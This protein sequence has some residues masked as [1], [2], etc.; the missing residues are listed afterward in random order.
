MIF[1]ERE[2]I[3]VPILL[4]A[5]IIALLAASGS[6][7]QQ[8]DDQRR[9]IE[10]RRRQLELEGTQKQYERSQALS[11]KGLISETDLERDKNNVATAQLNYQQAVL[12]LLDLQPRLSV[13]SAVKT[14]TPDGRKFVQLV[15]ANLTPTFDDSQFKLLNNFQGADPIP[16]ALRTRVI[17]DIFVSLR[18]TGAPAGSESNTSRAVGATISLPYE[19]H[20]PQMKYSETK[21]LRYQLLRDV[22]S[23]VVAI[24]YRNQTQEVT[25]Q[26]QHAAGGSELQISS[27]QFSQ[28]GDLGSQA[29]YNITLERPTVDVRSFQLN[30]VNLPRQVS[31]SFVDLQTQARLS[32]I[33]FPTGVTRQV[34]GLRL[35]LPERSDEQVLV[36]QELRFWVLG[37]DEA[38]AAKFGEDRP[39]TEA[40]LAALGS[41]KL[42]LTVIPRGVGRIEVTAPSLFSEIETGQELET[43]LTVRSAGT[44]RLD[45]IKLL[46]EYP[47]NWRVELAPDIIPSLEIDR[48]EQ[49]K[50]RVIPPADVGVGDYEIRL[51]TESFAANRRVQSEDKVYRISVKS[52]ADLLK[53][54]ALIGGLLLL[55]IGIVVF[56][57]KT[58]RR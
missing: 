25:V 42:R 28:E 5:I 53:T 41:S 44:R 11:S 13:R 43:Q 27:S 2:K 6:P 35:F 10:V 3:F 50:L 37:L 21:P 4:S 54:G 34:L 52:K 20:I 22:D 56:G 58:T 39:Y 57:I 46:A 19:I 15:I 31:Y 26:L 48:E 9:F 47:L 38:M 49:I 29:T 40:E 7:A 32:Q 18:D 24:A 8:G 55:V 51:K 36:D 12:A 33:N 1:R 14:Q 30:V 45:N 16:E 17:N 23:V